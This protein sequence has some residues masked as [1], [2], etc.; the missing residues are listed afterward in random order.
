[1]RLVVIVIRILP[2]NHDTHIRQ[3]RQFE[4]SIDVVGSGEYTMPPAFSLD[5]RLQ[6][7]EIPF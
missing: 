1:M 4:G 2:Q 3:R 7:P 5:E 6:F